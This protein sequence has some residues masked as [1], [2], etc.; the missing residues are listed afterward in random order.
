M[1]AKDTL[2]ELVYEA[3]LK[4]VDMVEHGA[5]LQSILA[6]EVPFP[7]SGLRVDFVFEGLIQ[8]RIAGDI[9]GVDY[10]LMRQDGGG[11]LDIH[12][13]VTTSDG[14]RIALSAEG[15]SIP[16]PHSTVSSIREGVRLATADEAYSWVNGLHI[17]GIG[18]A[19]IATG[20]VDIRAYVPNE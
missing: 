20:N 7:P 15:V 11:E 18:T 17:F 10:V 6:G 19:D 12:A 5:S 13:T 16:R 9:R 1:S 8:G 14:A 4:I 3:K 2:G